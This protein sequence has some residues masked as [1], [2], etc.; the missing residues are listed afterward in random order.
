MFNNF[1]S[2][3]RGGWPGT[4]PPGAGTPPM[5]PLFS[6]S[7]R[8]CPTFPAETETYQSFILDSVCNTWCLDDVT[9]GRSK[10][11]KSLARDFQIH[12]V[13]NVY[14]ADTGQ[15][16]YILM[17][18]SSPEPRLAI[19]PIYDHLNRR[20]RRYFPGICVFPNCPNRLL[21]ELIWYMIRNTPATTLTLFQRH[22]FMLLANGQL[23]FASKPVDPLFP[24]QILSDSLRI[25]V[26]TQ[27]PDPTVI[28]DWIDL[29]GTHSKLILLGLLLV[30]S[31]LLF[32]FAQ[33]GLYP[34]FQVVIRPSDGLTAEQLTAMLCLFDEQS[35]P[36]PNLEQTEKTIREY[37]NCL[38]DEIALFHDS[39][40]ADES[41]KIEGTLRLLAKQ[42]GADDC[43]S[44]GRNIVV[45]VS[46]YASYTARCLP[47]GVFLALD[48]DDVQLDADCKFIRR[49]VKSMESLIISTIQSRTD[50]V[51]K[52]MGEMV[53]SFRTA[54][55]ETNQ[56]AGECDTAVKMLCA[57]ARFLK[58]FLDIDTIQS[59][60]I[61]Q[62]LTDISRQSDLIQ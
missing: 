21:N 53:E 31:L 29:F 24:D 47:D 59:E 40:F 39:T 56:S 60:D 4:I 43:N 33:V 23:V 27:L 22:G 15:L 58:R 55:S 14:D 50:E 9:N 2:M 13:V 1:D 19:I 38:W 35:F 62:L 49:T 45:V 54:D 11:R 8:D 61:I 6:E 34:D 57:A 26:L 37:L 52:F 20:Y 10:K 32:F 25:R 36:I 12:M 5:P 17:Q 28:Q 18:Y 41:R 44:V 30:A 48:F 3:N 7:R 16:R 46:K 51:M 42:S